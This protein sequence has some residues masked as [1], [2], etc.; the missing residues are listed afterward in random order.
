MAPDE[1]VTVGFEAV[2]VLTALVAVVITCGV[3]GIAAPMP[4]ELS[5]T[6]MTPELPVALGAVPIPGA[7]AVEVTT[8]TTGPIVVPVPVAG[9]AETVIAALLA[10][11]AVPVDE[12]VVGVT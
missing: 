6:A 8:E 9:F 4:G 2:P 11:V 1:V 5:T 12:S 7:V 10:V 3:A